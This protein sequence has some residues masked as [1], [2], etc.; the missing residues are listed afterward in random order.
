MDY[1]ALLDLAID[2]A[3]QAAIKIMQVYKESDFDVEMKSDDTPLTRA[4]LIA[5]HL[6]VEALQKATP[7]Y[8]V[9]SEEST[10]IDWETRKKWHTYWLI[11]PLDGTKEFVERNDEFT[12]NIALINNGEPVVGVVVAPALKLSYFA[13]KGIAAYKKSTGEKTTSIRVRSVPESNG[14]RKF[15]LVIGRRSHSQRLE[16]VYTKLINYEKVL[17]GSSLKMCRIAEGKADLYP[18]FGKISEWDTAAAQ[19]VIESAGGSV[20]DLELKPLQYN[21]KESLL[22]PDLIAWGDAKIP[23]HN[24]VT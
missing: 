24:F 3:E 13:A 22:N 19:C 14:H 17:L 8:P 15:T 12:V 6:I 7:E 16:A 4:D 9:L 2:V 10:D 1:Q 11:D 5:H 18:R 23:W 20:T 21:T